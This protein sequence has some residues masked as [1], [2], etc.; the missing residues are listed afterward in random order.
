MTTAE[1]KRILLNNI[2]GVDIDPQA[3]EVTK[4]SLLLKV[5]EGESQETLERQRRMFHERALPDL[6]SNIKCGNSLIGREFFNG[7]QLSLFDEEERFKI[8]V[9]DWE[10]E[11]SAIMRLGGFDAVIGNPPYVRIQTMR[12]WAP[13]EVDHFKQHYKAAAKGNYD[14]YVVFAERGLQLLNRQ[15]R[16]GFIMPH[17][18]FNAEYGQP[19][20][21]LLAQGKHLAEI[22][23]FGHQQVFA[24]ATTYTCLM[25]LDKAGCGT[26][27]FVRVDDLTAWKGNGGA[28]DGAIPASAITGAEWNFSVGNGAAHP[29][30]TGRYARE[31]RRCGGT[32]L[33]APRPAPT[34][35]LSSMIAGVPKTSS[36][37]DR[38]R[39]ARK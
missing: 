22:V 2:Y 33:S 29:Q 24:G 37:E 15:G 11:F 26:C 19:I 30:E 6:A 14:I 38:N 1:R 32:S 25:F 28:V 31:A 34:K 39:W 9:F 13:L 7:H 35:S 4:L 23:H 27:R 5:L 10:A 16:F 36:S 8:N 18:F 20:R 12:K 21:E 17:K 3:V